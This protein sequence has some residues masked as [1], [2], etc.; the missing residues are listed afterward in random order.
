[1]EDEVQW[2]FCVS[3]FAFCSSIFLQMLYHICR[4]EPLDMFR[5]F[6]ENCCTRSV[7]SGFQLLQKEQNTRSWINRLLLGQKELSLVFS[8]QLLLHLM[9][10]SW[11]ALY[12]AFK[13]EYR[14]M[15]KTFSLFI[16]GYAPFTR[17]IIFSLYKSLSSPPN[18]SAGRKL[19]RDIFPSRFTQALTL[20]DF[21][22]TVTRELHNSLLRSIRTP[23]Q[24]HSLLKN[25]VFGNVT[26]SAAPT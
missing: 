7:S 2:L 18:R 23:L 19:T 3:I 20:Q 6:Q 13:M 14:G 17:F 25:N 21:L 26:P 10:R 22:R 9:K 8:A 5:D 12:V 24:F 15:H 4:C 16:S 11:C 1:M